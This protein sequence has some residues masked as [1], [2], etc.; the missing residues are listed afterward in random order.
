MWIIPYRAKFPWIQAISGNGQLCVCVWACADQ[1]LIKLNYRAEM[2]IVRLRLPSSFPVG[3]A[4][5]WAVGVTVLLNYWQCSAGTLVSVSVWSVVCEW[6]CVTVWFTVCSH[7]CTQICCA[8]LWV[9]VVV[10]RLCPFFHWSEFAVNNLI[11]YFQEVQ[12]EVILSDP[13][14]KYL[15]YH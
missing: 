1:P 5:W 2:L 9:M 14:E 3:L 7:V 8:S 11:Y 13:A 10:I 6:V 4:G 15:D 12:S